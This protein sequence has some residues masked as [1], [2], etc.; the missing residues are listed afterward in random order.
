MC[1]GHNSNTHVNLCKAPNTNSSG[2][3]VFLISILQ[4]RKFEG[5]GG[6]VID[7]KLTASKVHT[8]QYDCRIYP[9]H[10]YAGLPLW[11]AFLLHPRSVQAS[12]GA[13]S[14]DNLH[15]AVPYQNIMNLFMT[16]LSNLSTCSMTI[17]WNLL[18]IF[19]L[20]LCSSSSTFWFIL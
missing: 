4:M 18:F 15:T 7:W 19:F 1:A 14:P 17:D 8:Q 10:H 11:K 16:N 6:K 2:Q 5:K 12:Q 13:W 3:V 20:N 9:P